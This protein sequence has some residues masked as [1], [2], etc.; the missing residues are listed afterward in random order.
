[1]TVLVV[2]TILLLLRNRYLE[3]KLSKK[4][5]LPL[6]LVGIAL[7][8]PRIMEYDVAPLTVVMALVAWRY[9]GQVTKTLSTRVIGI[10]SSF[11]ALN[12]YAV[13]AWRFTEGVTLTALFFAGAWTLFSQVQA[14]PEGAI[15][16]TP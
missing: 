9:F 14:Q 13:Y 2:G 8:N 6:M 7:L 15:S 12:G 4:Q 16:S 10:S 1:V 11:A 5:W 3:G